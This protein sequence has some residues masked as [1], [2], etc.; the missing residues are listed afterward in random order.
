MAS[1][2]VTIGEL[3]EEYLFDCQARKLSPKTIEGYKKL[4]G[5]FQRFLGEDEYITTKDPC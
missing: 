5:M 3:V 4:L 2:K 1:V